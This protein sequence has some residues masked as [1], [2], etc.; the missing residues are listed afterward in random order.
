MSQQAGRSSSAFERLAPPIQRWVWAQKWTALRDIQEQAIDPILDGRDVV[1]A[2]ATASG[3]TE[4]AFLPLLSRLTAVDQQRD[5]LRIL[6]LSPLKALIN[7]Q[8]RRLEPMAETVGMPVTPWHGDVAAS[9][10]KRLRATPAGILLITPESLEAMFVLRGSSVSAF[11]AGVDAVVIDELHSFIATERGRQLQSLLHR[12][13]LAVGRTIPRI[14]LSATLGDL[15][16]AAT[17]LRPTATVDLAPVIVQSTAQQNEVLIQVRGYERPERAPGPDDAPDADQLAIAAHLYG[18]TS[19]GTHLVFANSRAKVE[20]MVDLLRRLAEHTT[21]ADEFRPHHGSLAKEVREEAEAA[22]RS[23]RPATVV[24]TT[25]LELGIDVGSVDAIAQIDTPPSVASMRQRLG[26]S[27][28]RAGVPST[29]RIYVTEDEVTSR[30]PPH[31]QLREDVAQAVA[32]IL[33][34]A[35]RFNESP[36]PGALHLSTLTQ[37]VL[38]IAAQRGGFR[39][40]DA[41]RALCAPGPFADVSASMFGDLLRDLAAHD[42]LVQTGDGTVVLGLQGE[43]LVNRHDFYSAFITSDEFRLVAGTRT[44]GT[45]PISRPLAVDDHILFAGR[46]WRVLEI[47]DAERLI[48]LEPAPGGRAPGFNGSGAL[49]DDAIRHKMRKVLADTAVPAFLDREAQRLLAEGRDAYT[50]LDLSVQSVLAWGTDVVLFAWEGDRTLDTLALLLA[51]AGLKAGRDGLAVLVQQSDVDT[52]NAALC[53]VIA[54]PPEPEQLAQAVENKQT[55]K[56]HQFLGENLLDAD[57][58]SSRLDLTPA[59]RAA[60]RLSTP[61]EHET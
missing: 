57:W 29:L 9:R 33:L 32:M 30:T 56:H 18:V 54:A 37:Q 15:G 35:A 48:Q 26:R 41:W 38:S 51:S 60:A 52:V 4:A 11:F 7:D 24:A 53:A 21:T 6:S 19:G 47:R 1:I 12:V 43:R 31:A 20:S 3:K 45:L 23:G 42:L 46:R 61:T 40:A 44:L 25:S 22:L 14:G 27:G 49:V 55:E 16:L 2:S 50:R 28:R 34:L 17:F 5:G 39:A 36:R 58:A 8:A 10:K 13:E 59:L